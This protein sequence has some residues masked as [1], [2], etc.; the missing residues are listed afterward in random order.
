MHVN[1]LSQQIYSRLCE[2]IPGGV[3]SPA[4][5]FKGMDQIPLIVSHASRDLV[6]DVEGNAFIDYC[7]SWGPLLHGHA[8]PTILEAVQKRMAMGITFGITSEIEERLA[9]RITQLIHSI[10]KIR[11]VS[12]GT[13]A[14]M[15]AIRL[16]RG[17][18]KRD[19]I[20]KFTGNY[21]GHAD[22]FLVQAGSGLFGLNPSSSSA[23]IPEDILRH[24]ACLPF[25]DLEVCKQFILDP[26]NRKRIAAVIV[27]P[28]AGNMGCVPATQEFLNM[29]RE[30]TQEIGA[31]L[32]FDEV[33]T[34]FRVGLGGAQALYQIK[35]DLTCLG[36]IVGGG[37]PA[38]AFGG[39]ADIMDYLAPLGPV[40]QAGTLSGNPIA[41]EAGFQTLS[42]AL[43]KG[44]YDDLK[45]KTDLIT[46]PVGQLL[47][48]K[49]INACLQQVGSMF[50]IFFGRKQVSN[51]EEAHGLDTQEFARFFRFMRAN[52]VYIP[53]SQYEVCFV[54][55][56][57]E[58][59]HLE[60]TRDIMLKFFN[61][62]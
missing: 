49:N 51:M 50:T 60:K 40:Y 17:F 41:M 31:L 43:G 10:E 48:Q 14:T 13:E 55:S 46:Q 25:N 21:H 53:P 26:S 4:R 44:F 39:R 57:H 3:N 16:A 12:S 15:S 61:D 30:S 54:S 22:F 38:A 24:T 23:G 62:K 34:G 37:F 45:R 42:L 6:Y 58:Q 36:K 5:A 1:S 28:I 27:E 32:V 52:G 29:L 9:R 2:V 8:H 19:L 11:F 18:T 56:V 20:V 33:I 35:P 59:G 7:G 47:K